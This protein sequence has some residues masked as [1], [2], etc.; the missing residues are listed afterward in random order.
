MKFVGCVL[1]LSACALMFG[2]T[3]A[4]PQPSDGNIWDI[5]G[6]DEVYN[7][8]VQTPSYGDEMRNGWHLRGDGLMG[9]QCPVCGCDNA[10]KGPD[11][12][13][14]IACC[15]FMEVN[16]SGTRWMIVLIPLRIY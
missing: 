7:H 14:G 2:V 16:F 4:A 9:R 3:P 13:G 8:E 10:I 5:W 1:I 6:W 15:C 11:G 12:T